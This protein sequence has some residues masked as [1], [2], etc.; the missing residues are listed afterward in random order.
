MGTEAILK[1]LEGVGH[2]DTGRHV[3]IERSMRE[4]AGMLVCSCRTLLNSLENL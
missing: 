3:G 4:V 1:V 2:G